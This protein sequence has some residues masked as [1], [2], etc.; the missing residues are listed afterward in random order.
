M[1]VF[2]VI[3]GVASL[4]ELLLKS[5]KTLRK[6]QHDL[7]EAKD[8]I[9]RLCRAMQRLQHVMDE[10]ETLGTIHGKDDESLWTRSSLA[11]HWAE[12]SASVK[13]DLLGLVAKLDDLHVAFEKPS[14]TRNNVRARFRKVFAEHDIERYERILQDH[15]TSFSFMLSMLAE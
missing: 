11:A 7:I 8:E 13:V 3:A 2:G 14:K 15:R 5:F 1:E 9:D 12:H 6:L 4:S 10:V